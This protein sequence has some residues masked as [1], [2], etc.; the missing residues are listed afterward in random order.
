MKRSRTPPAVAT[1]AEGAAAGDGNSTD[2]LVAQLAAL[3]AKRAA[4]K[5]GESEEY[6]AHKAQLVEV[7]DA[8][9]S[10][11]NKYAAE[12]A[13][14]TEKLREFE[15]QQATQ[16]CDSQLLKHKKELLATVDEERKRVKQ[17]IESGASAAD[18]DSRS[19]VTTRKL[20]SKVKVDDDDDEGDRKKLRKTKD[21]ASRPAPRVQRER[22]SPSA[23]HLP[24]SC[25]PTQRC[26]A[27]SAHRLAHALPRATPQSHSIRLT[28]PPSLDPFPH[29]QRSTIRR[30]S[31][32]SRR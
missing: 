5:A 17:L 30:R 25:V 32:S 7:Q 29:P 13:R 28:L 26:G 16:A 4:I 23:A 12:R 18:D 11:S 22:G 14:N 1:D 8:E 31:R 15:V 10:Q 21:R 6:L 20:R 9:I 3:D 19:R 27:A 2:E 24:L